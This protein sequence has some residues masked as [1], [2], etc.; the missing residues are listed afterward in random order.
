VPPGSA[1]SSERRATPQS[2]NEDLSERADHDVARFQIAVDDAARVREGDR[3]ADLAKDREAI[4]QSRSRRG[5]LVEP[6][7]FDAFHGVE[8]ASVRKDARVVNRNEPGVLEARH[9]PGFAKKNVQVLRLRRLPVEHLEGDG[10][11]EN[12]VV[13]E[14]NGPMPPRPISS[15]IV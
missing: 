14:V 2:E 1:G 10:A 4:G 6:R 11:I 8:D 12:R 13:G 9:H 7:A 5:K 15:R 3:L